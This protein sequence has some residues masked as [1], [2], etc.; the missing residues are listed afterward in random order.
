MTNLKENINFLK[1]KSRKKTIESILEIH[2]ESD[3]ICI[4]YDKK[5]ITYKE[6][7]KM[8]NILS[9]LFNKMMLHRVILYMKNSPDFI[10]AYFA[11]IKANITVIPLNTTLSVNELEDSYRFCNADLILIDEIDLNKK[12]STD[13]NYTSINQVRN[14]NIKMENFS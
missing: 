2:K 5:S 4:D 1:V 8:I 11:L 3:D 6:L 10:V 12:F 14:F 7:Y 9:G 13:I